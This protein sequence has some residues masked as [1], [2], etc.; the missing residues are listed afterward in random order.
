MRTLR[1]LLCSAG[2]LATSELPLSVS[3]SPRPPAEAH[4]SAAKPNVRP[5]NATGDRTQK[6]APSNVTTQTAET[7]KSA[8]QPKQ[9]RL[10]LRESSA[11]SSAAIDRAHPKQAPGHRA[12]EADSEHVRS[13]T[14]VPLHQCDRWPNLFFGSSVSR[15]PTEIRRPVQARSAA[16]NLPSAPASRTQ[17]GY[18][19]VFSPESK[20][21]SAS[22]PSATSSHTPTIAHSQTLP[23]FEKMP[24]LPAR[25]P[26]QNNTSHTVPLAVPMAERAPAQA[27]AET[28]VEAAAFAAPTLEDLE[29]IAKAL[30][31]TSA[32]PEPAAITEPANAAGTL[33][34]EAIVE[35]SVAMPQEESGQQLL[36]PMFPQSRVIPRPAPKA[37]EVLPPSLQSLQSRQPPPT[38]VDR[39]SSTPR[40]AEA[41][42]SSGSALPA[43][44]NASRPTDTVA[45]ALGT[46]PSPDKKAAPRDPQVETKPLAA[47]RLEPGGLR[48]TVRIVSA[49]SSPGANADFWFGN[50]EHISGVVHGEIAG[51]VDLH[52]PLLGS[53]S[54]SRNHVAGQLVEI[55]L[56]NGDRLVGDL[57]SETADAVEI[58]HSS[59]GT[60]CVRRSEICPRVA[61]YLLKNGDRIVGEVLSENATTIELRTS[62]LGLIKVPRSSIQRVLQ[63]TY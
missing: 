12:H 46:S 52:H 40:S 18:P 1:S 41:K 11:R 58:R 22:E 17:L 14:H 43:D 59:L 15:T 47:A 19:R 50:G 53:L 54:V 5:S 39:A 42:S 4:A 60:I 44:S 21:R 16:L 63:Q 49:T 38:D 23:V 45:E 30:S 25:G 3:I 34:D 24:A 27:Q 48:R 37:G 26:S 10:P 51:R 13:A 35:E 33:A 36:F 9:S 28:V 62:A 8:T 20:L 56:R 61:N 31:E 29:P 7:Q 2:I 6:R 55:F 57:I 32:Q